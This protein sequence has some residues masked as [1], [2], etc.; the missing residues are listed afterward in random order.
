[1]FGV[2]VESK[3]NDSD[4]EMEI[5]AT[6]PEM[7]SFFLIPH[8]LHP[9]PHVAPISTTVQL[10]SSVSVDSGGSG[11]FSQVPLVSINDEWSSEARLSLTILTAHPQIITFFFQ[12]IPS[13]FQAVPSKAQTNCISKASLFTRRH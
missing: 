5:D 9:R 10:D 7:S 8:I 6:Q 13:T 11:L 2:T 3:K 12:G 4:K 1:M